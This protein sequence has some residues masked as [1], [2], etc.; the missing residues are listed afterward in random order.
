MLIMYSTGVKLFM[1]SSNY[2]SYCLSAVTAS[3][4]TTNQIWCEFDRSPTCNQQ[5]CII[6]YCTVYKKL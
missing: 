6:I 2:R 4:D 1:P 5:V 3:K